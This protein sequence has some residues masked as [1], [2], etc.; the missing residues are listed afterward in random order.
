MTMVLRTALATGV[1]SLDRNHGT[2]VAASASN[3]SFFH[4]KSDAIAGVRIG[5][6][7][8]GSAVAGSDRR[9]RMIFR[10]G[11]RSTPE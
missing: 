8:V 1:L 7:A 4:R 2:S 9:I 11:G 5:P 6:R 3:S 10:A